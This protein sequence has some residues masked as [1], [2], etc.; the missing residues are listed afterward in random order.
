VEGVVKVTVGQDIDLKCQICGNPEF[1]E[2]QAQLNTAVM[3]FMGLD[4][5]NKSARCFVC[6]RCGYVHWFLPRKQ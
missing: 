1:E 5:L 2:Q 6:L 4:W 3:S